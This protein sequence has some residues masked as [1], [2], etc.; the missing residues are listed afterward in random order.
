MATVLELDRPIKRK[1]TAGTVHW[2]NQ[3]IE[4]GKCEPFAEVVKIT[5]GLADHILKF[6]P[7]N[8][9]LK[10]VKQGQYATDICAGQWKLNGETVIVA[11]DGF[12]NDGQ[13]RLTAVVEAGL[14]IDTFIAFG[15]ERET[16][17]TVDQGAA[18]TAGDYL[19]MLG[20]SHGN[21]IAGIA[22]LVMAYEASGGK[23]IGKA[24]DFTNAE[25]VQRGLNDAAVGRAACYA[26]VAARH[27]RFLAAPSIIGA[28]L[29]ILRNEDEAVADE[30]MNQIAYGENIRRGDPAYA[31]RSALTNLDRLDKS[32]RMEMIFR[33]WNAYRKN[34]PLTLAKSLGT[35]PALV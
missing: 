2:F 10:P 23:S 18:R 24:K 8:R 11:K 35:F 20:V 34:R 13:N 16:R 6:N 9:K 4:R 14:P 1:I 3:C 26:N 30:Y 7:D 25:V 21:Q 22:R 5:P 33:G 32:A 31:V 15:V 29:Y 17:T 19:A 27:T 28:C 12:L